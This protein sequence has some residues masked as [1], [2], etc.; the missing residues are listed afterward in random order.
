MDALES[1]ERWFQSPHLTCVECE[2]SFSDA[3]GSSPPGPHLTCVECELSMGSTL[4]SFTTGP[5]LTCVECEQLRK[6]A[7]AFLKTPSSSDLCGM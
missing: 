3:G 6:V 7:V 5:H 2:R 1:R 4:F